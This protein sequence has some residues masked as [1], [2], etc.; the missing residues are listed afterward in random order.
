MVRLATLQKGRSGPLGMPWSAM[1]EEV[2]LIDRA[3]SGDGSAAGE[4]LQRYQRRVYGLCL[5][6]LGST[7]D[8]EELTQET[9]VKALMGLERFDGRST[10]STWLY[11]IATN[12]CLSRLRSDRVR[13]K[14]RV[15]SLP[16]MELSSRPSVQTAEGAFDASGRRRAVSVGLGQIAP[17][18]RVVLVLRDVQGLEYEQVAAVLGVPVGTIK[19]RLFRARVALRRALEQAHGAPIDG[20]AEDRTDR[21]EGASR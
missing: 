3:R 8:A 7:E 5:R 14:A 1:D 11:R 17:E 19:S 18:H 20:H 13:S 21:S 4:L 12:A 16:D 10:F 15:A 2:H 9:F 6:M